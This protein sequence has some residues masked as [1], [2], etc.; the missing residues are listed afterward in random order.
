MDYNVS[1]AHRAVRDLLPAEVHRQGFDTTNTRQPT[2][3][4]FPLYGTQGS[5]REAYTGAF[6][7]SLGQNLVNEAR[8]AYSG[9]PVEFGPYHERSMYHRFARESGRILTRT[10]RGVR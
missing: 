5:L 1:S 8:V 2:W 10:Q 4:G 3:P 7:S 9:A 6:R